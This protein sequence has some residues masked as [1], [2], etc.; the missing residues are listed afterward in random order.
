MQCDSSA[1]GAMIL[2]VCKIP[3]MRFGK[4]LRTNRAGCLVPQIDAHIDI[5]VS[6]RMIVNLVPANATRAVVSVLRIRISVLSAT[7]NIIANGTFCSVIITRYFQSQIVCF[8]VC[9]TACSTSGVCC[10]LVC[11][12][13]YAC[14]LFAI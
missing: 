14:A 5:V 13:E 11:E 9:K 7:L 1:F 8:C 10:E 4:R 3:V 6:C 12:Y 2:V